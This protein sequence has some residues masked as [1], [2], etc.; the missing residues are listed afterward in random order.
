MALGL[1]V[2]TDIIQ[3]TLTYFVRGDALSQTTQDKPLL[4]YLKEGQQTFPGGKDNISEPIQGKYMSDSPGFLQG[5]SEDDT[6]TFAQASNLQ[7]AAY[8]WKEVHVGLIITWTELKKDGITVRDSMKT[9]DHS[10]VDMIRLTGLMTNRLADFAE[11][12]SRAKNTMF[13][14]DGAQDPKQ[15]A[16]V[17]SLIQDAGPAVIGGVDGN[18]YPWWNPI[19]RTGAKAVQVSEANQTLTKAIRHDMLQLRRY[20]GKPNKAFCGSVAVD[21]IWTE[22]QAKGQYTL[23]G[24]NSRDKVQVAMAFA[25]IDNLEFEY[26]PTLDDMGLGARIYILDGRRLK[27]RPME[28]EED[29][30]LTPERPYNYLVF[31][32]SMTYTGGM[33]VTQLNCHEIIDTK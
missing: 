24:F 19:N 3:A 18:T 10:Q 29:K 14:L 6:L 21:N 9:S 23:S 7:R 4:R 1:V 12:Y 8:P 20:G 33:E 13:W 27:L 30:L 11:S 31:L 22:I 15:I 26:D 16:G 28:G 25:R 32:R 2:A 17:R 5:Y